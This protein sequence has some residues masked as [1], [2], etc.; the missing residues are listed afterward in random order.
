MTG[1]EERKKRN[2]KDS[3]KTINKTAKVSSYLL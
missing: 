1:R 2:L 3:K